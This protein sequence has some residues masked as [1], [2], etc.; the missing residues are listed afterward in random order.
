MRALP[1]GYEIRPATLDDLDAVAAV[2][3]AVDADVTGGSDL[4]A[5]MIQD[6]WSSPGIDL[7][8]DAWVVFTGD[9]VVAYAHVQEDGATRLKGW[10]DVHPDHRDR[11]IGSVILE[12]AEARATERFVAVPEGVLD[13]AAADGNDEAAAL[14]R[15]RGFEYARSFRHM[16]IDLGGSPVDPG[17]PPDGIEIRGIEPERDL[18]EI[19]A[20][21][22]DAFRDEWGYREVPFEEWKGNEVDT[23]SFDPGFW[24][25][26]EDESGPVGAVS[27]LIWGELGWVGELGVRKP[28]RGRGIA[29]A[30][31]RR[32]FSTFGSRGL[33]RVRLNVDAENPTGAVALYERVGMHKVR[34]WDIY[35]KRFG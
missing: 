30:L 28:R 24:F 25:I 6:L 4:D 35:E 17:E 14:M 1:E 33:T 34:G 7:A 13:L 8:L 5:D 23:P 22:V 11:G 32:S 20:I 3:R 9:A 27:G 15:S 18:P 12:R 19:H 16:Q 10:G 29:A 2:M 26:A 21:F 31:L